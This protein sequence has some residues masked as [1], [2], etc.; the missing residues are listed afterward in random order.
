MVSGISSAS[1]ASLSALRQQM[2]NKIDT[3]GDGSI[4]KSEMTALIEGNTSSLVSS[5]FGSQDSDQD[6]LISQ[7][8]FDSTM[9]QLGQQM[10]QGGGTSAA[11]GPPPPPEKVF[12]TAD[13]NKDGVV[14]KDELAAVIGDGGGNIDELFSQVDTDGDGSITRAEDN[15]FLAKMKEGKMGENASSASGMSGPPP[16]PEKVFDTADTNKDGVVTK[17]ELAAVMGNGGGNIDELFSQVDADGDG[18]I[19]RAEDEVFR[20]QMQTEKEGNQFSG[21]VTENSYETDWQAQMLN[22]LIQS[23]TASSTESSGALTSF[24]A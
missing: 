19:T 13:T 2:F 14:T 20:A 17:A 4:D 12:D 3:N 21:I 8:E 6:G 7:I 15:A 11:S 24:Y 5:I 9:A 16:R 1:T 23:L 22:A 10:K 18:S